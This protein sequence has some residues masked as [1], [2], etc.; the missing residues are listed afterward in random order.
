MTLA[1]ARDR[2]APRVLFFASC[3]DGCMCAWP[4]MTI[5]T[6]YQGI[7]TLGTL[8]SA[9][10]A[11]GNCYDKA[12]VGDCPDAAP[13]FSVRVVIGNFHKMLEPWGGREK[14]PFFLK[15]RH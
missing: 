13:I 12:K 2:V 14:Y 7:A 11:V 10:G 1:A 6:P 3:R 8:T 4:C 15:M 9:G 5:L